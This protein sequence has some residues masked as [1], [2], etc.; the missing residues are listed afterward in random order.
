MKNA[1][2]PVK[3]YGGGKRIGEFIFINDKKSLKLENCNDFLLSK[4]KKFF[5]VSATIPQCNIEFLENP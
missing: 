5:L 1:K 2:I 4:N 3:K